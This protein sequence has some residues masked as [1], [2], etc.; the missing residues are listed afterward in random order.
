M[1]RYNNNGGDG[2]MRVGLEKWKIVVFFAKHV[3]FLYSC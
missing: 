3:S 2:T 1:V